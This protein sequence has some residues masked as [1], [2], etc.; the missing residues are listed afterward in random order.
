MSCGL[1]AQY[2]IDTLGLTSHPEGGWFKE[3]FRD[4]TLIQQG[5]RNASTGI[6]FLVESG[7]PSCLHRIGASEMWHFYAGDPLVVHQLCTQKGY[8]RHLLGQN[9]Q[10]GERFQAVVPP[11]VWFGAQTLGAYSLVGC[12]VAPG[13]DFADFTL[14]T[15]QALQELFPQYGDVV[16]MLTR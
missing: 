1:S 6:Y 11:N 15:R 12:T 3:T 8:Q 7:A 16:E 14:G 10:K 13:F 5:T 2:W 4:E 9:W